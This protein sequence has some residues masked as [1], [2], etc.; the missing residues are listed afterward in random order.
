MSSSLS[1]LLPSSSLSSDHYSSYDLAILNLACLHLL[2]TF[3]AAVFVLLFH[4][5]SPSPSPRHSLRRRR[6]S[7]LLH[8]QSSLWPVRL[9]LLLFASILSLSELLRLPPFFLC[10][11]HSLASHSF[12]QPA[13]FATLLFLLRASVKTSSSSSLSLTFAFSIS[14]LAALPFLILQA[15]LVFLSSTTLTPV[16]TGKSTSIDRRCTHHLYT[17]VL[18]AL[19][20]AIYIPLFISACLNAATVVINNKLRVRLYLLVGT[21]VATLSVQVVSLALSSLWSP[22]LTVSQV[23]ELISYVAVLVCVVVGEG[24]LVVQP[25]VDMLAIAEPEQSVC[26]SWGGAGDGKLEA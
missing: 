2:S 24:I 9:L 13:F 12:A 3:V 21:V 18:L 17:T 4:R 23:L 26:E 15:L 8:L 1:S 11:A 16:T 7:L 20:G 22:N 5:S 14:I 6:L 25:M 19:L 10:N